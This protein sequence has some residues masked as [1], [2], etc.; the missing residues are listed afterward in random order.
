MDPSF[1]RA[2]EKWQ[3]KR[4]LIFC[5]D[6]KGMGAGIAVDYFFIENF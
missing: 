6:S 4:L 5:S 3:K 1:V 2:W